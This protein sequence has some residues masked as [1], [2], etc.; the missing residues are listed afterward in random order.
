MSDGVMNHQQS[1]PRTYRFA[2]RAFDIIAATLG[3]ILTS[4]ITFP[5]A[6]AV[7]LG[8]GRPV[9]Y[10]GLRVGR[11]G[12]HFRILK[13]RT[14][15]NSAHQIGPAITYAHDPRVTAIGRFLRRT[16]LDELPQLAN[17]IVGDMSFVGPRPEDP[18]YVRDYTR[19][20]RRILEVRPGI[21]SVATL[22]YRSE[23][24]LLKGPNPDSQYVAILSE[25]LAL[26]LEYIDHRTFWSDMKLILATVVRWPRLATPR[27][28]V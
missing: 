14:M 7:L 2:K 23:E 24:H 18:R 16:K 28:D 1:S 11:N 4:P 27:G 26:D 19:E 3:L 5:L 8:D 13:F 25:K 17:V 20:Q 9:L 15:V 21:T 10:R 22:R 6:L 12:R